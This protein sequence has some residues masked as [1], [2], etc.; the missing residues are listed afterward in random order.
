MFAVDPRRFKTHLSCLSTV[1]LLASILSH[2]VHAQ[3]GS[4]AVRSSRHKAALPQG[5]VLIGGLRVVTGKPNS[6]VY[7]VNVRQGVTNDADV[8]DLPRLKA[9]KYSLKVRTRG[10]IDWRGSVVV[11]AGATRTVK[12]TQ[13]ASSDQAELHYQ[14]GDELREKGKHEEA[15]GEYNEAL[16]LRPS[17][18]EA[19]VALARSLTTLQRFDEAEKQIE[20]SVRDHRGP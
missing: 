11:A 19:R 5:D 16:A 9:G 14:E 10:C 3:A 15:A 18:P 7:L 17:F 13:P 6:A 12:V 1:L 4:G 2:A 8:L 20:A